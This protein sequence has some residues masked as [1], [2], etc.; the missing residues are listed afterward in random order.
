[1]RRLIIAIDCDDVLLRTTTFFVTA[2]NK[3]YGTK[4]TLK[5]AHTSGSPWGVSGPE[6][7][8]RLAELMETDE[9]KQL[10]PTDEEVAVLKELS[11]N[12]EMHVVTARRTHE[13]ELTQHMLDTYF[14]GIFSSLELVGFTGSKGDVTQRIHADVLVDDNVRHLADAV[15][16]GLPE[17]G[18]LLFGDYPWNMSEETNVVRCSSW[19]N[20]KKEIDRLA[21]TT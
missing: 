8:S 21:R 13:R 19:K 3:I 14:P 18:A 1:M 12:H 16:H 20:V 11:S 7:E 9:Y 6:L 5:D 2:Y 17:A 4:V 15:S 10:S